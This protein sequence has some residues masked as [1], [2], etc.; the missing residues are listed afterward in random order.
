M[1]NDMVQKRH[2]QQDVIIYVGLSDVVVMGL[3]ELCWCDKLF[4]NVLTLLMTD[5]CEQTV[6][7]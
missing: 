6:N 7:M 5:H 4:R 3:I 2:R 1:E